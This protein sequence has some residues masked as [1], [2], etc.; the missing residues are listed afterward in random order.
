MPDI[1]QAKILIMATDGFEQSEL[2]VPRQ[3]LSEA[4]ATVEVAAPKS[5]M[6][7]AEIR[8]WD[9]KD[10]GKSVKV[11]KDVESVDPSS[12]DALVLPGGQINPDKLRTEQKAIEIIRAFYSSG[13]VI[14]AIC[15]APWL[16]VEAGV[17]K[18][19][20]CTSYHSIKT[21][22][23]NAGG[24]WRDE[25]VVADQGVI[26]SRNPGDLEAFV[27]KIVEE[28]REGS[29]AGRRQAAE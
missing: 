6:N 12:Y 4:G 17:I 22:I 16:L 9:E 21:D 2:M 26:T 29:H 28:V 1:Q 20:K 27:R 14:A 15:H 11:D 18:D 3:K 23:V 7:Q 13:K 10:W 8:G 19:K 24:E 5:R 25:T